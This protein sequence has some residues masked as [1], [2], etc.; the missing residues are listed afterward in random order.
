MSLFQTIALLIAFSCSFTAGLWSELAPPAATQQTKVVTAT[1][2]PCPY[3]KA[4][5][6][7]RA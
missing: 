5:A 2:Q 3:A 6:P 1:A 7:R 4:A